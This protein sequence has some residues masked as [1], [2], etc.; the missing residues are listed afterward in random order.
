MNAKGTKPKIAKAKVSKGGR[1]SG[2]K[3]YNRLIFIQLMR[4]IQPISGVEWTL[5]SNR[6]HEE[7]GEAL[8]RT[9]QAIKTQFFKV[10]CN[11]GQK[12]TGDSG[13]SPIHEAQSIWNSILSK[14][15]AGVF[16]DDEHQ[17][18]IGEN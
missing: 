16:G 1:K 9:I 13:G 8:P 10:Y 6:Y 17:Q 5:F 14:E 2:T 4:E 12:V 18:E 15:N 3:N 7:S 11:R